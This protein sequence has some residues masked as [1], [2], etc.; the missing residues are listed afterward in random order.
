MTSYVILGAS[1]AGLSAIEAIRQR[2]PSGPITL[3]SK[4]PEPCYSRVALPYLIAGEKDL[5]QITLQTP[6]Y[7]RSRGVEAI[8]GVG[9]AALDPQARQVRLEDGRTLSYDR[10][11]IAT[12]SRSRVPP[13]QGI[14]EAE[15]CYHWTLADAARIDRASEGARSCFVIG[16]GF[17]SLL[18]INALLKRR[19]GLRYTVVEIADQ[20]MPQLLDP[21]GGRRLEEE[22]RS[23][24]MEVLLGDAVSAVEQG[25]DGKFTLH[26]RSG[27]TYQ[28]D[29]VVCGTGVEPN[30]GFVQGSGLEVGRGIRTNERQETNLPG[31]YAAGD[32]AETRDF[33]SSEPVVHAIWP[34]A[35][36]QGR[37][38][39]ANMAGDSVTYPGSLS[40]NVTELFGLSC[41]SIG[42]F[43]DEPGLEPIVFR[44]RATGVYRK[45]L[46]DGENRV[47]GAVV[48]G[49]PQ[50]VQ[51]LGV[52]QAMVRRRT[53]VSRWKHRFT[54]ERINLG[55]IAFEALKA[56]LARR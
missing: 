43:R 4:E 33:I 36:D 30:I 49:R 7:F 2:D 42:K 31:V 17:I 39:G 20:V 54:H 56:Q 55:M 28:A 27:K 50:D 44:D 5:R 25:R 9:A 18:T 3:V 37:V 8:W 46:V 16:A 23:L 10:L 48:I 15:V 40:W 11:L 19:P 38:A 34:T 32:C 51:E 14:H 29:M 52:L 53:D 12:G 45:V 21:E 22:M 1:A 35:V 13:V 24:G 47:V 41:A 6:D 26:L